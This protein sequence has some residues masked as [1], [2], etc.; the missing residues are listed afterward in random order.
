MI[1]GPERSLE[2]DIEKKYRPQKNGFNT[3]GLI[4]LKILRVDSALSQ[5]VRVYLQ[6]V[7]T[8]KIRLVYT[9][10]YLLSDKAEMCRE[11]K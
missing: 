11:R 2:S 5:G 1:A 4:I 7:F 9:F 3:I 10:F 8:W 6:K